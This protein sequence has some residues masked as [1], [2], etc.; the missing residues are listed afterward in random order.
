[1]DNSQR[2]ERMQQLLEQELAT[3]QLDIT[4]DS[5]LH[6]GHAGARDGA[7]HFTVTIISAAFAGKSPSNDT[8]R[9]TRLSET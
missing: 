6:E 5:H 1:M 4:D 9:C 7:G 2:I 8:G 3:E